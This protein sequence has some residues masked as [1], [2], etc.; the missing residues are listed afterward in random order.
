MVNRQLLS[1]VCTAV[2]V[3]KRLDRKRE[4]QGWRETIER[5]NLKSRDRYATCHLVV[6]ASLERYIYP[7]AGGAGKNEREGSGL[8]LRFS[9]ARAI[10]GRW[11]GRDAANSDLVEILIRTRDR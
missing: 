2:G 6:D 7:C 10:G 1:F 9:L 3:D 11:R 5:K 8:E 4:S